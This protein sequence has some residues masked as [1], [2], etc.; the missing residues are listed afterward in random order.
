MALISQYFSRHSHTFLSMGVLSAISQ[1]SLTFWD[2]I[3]PNHSPFP[4]VFLDVCMYVCILNWGHAYST[5]VH[6]ASGWLLHIWQSCV[7]QPY[8]GME[9][10]WEHGVSVCGIYLTSWSEHRLWGV[11]LRAGCTALFEWSALDLVPG[12]YV[13]MYMYWLATNWKALFPN[14]QWRNSPQRRLVF[15]LFFFFL[16]RLKDGRALWWR[17][18]F[19]LSDT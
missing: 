14:G 18:S 15:Y 12:I 10:F 17:N 13:Y 3:L 6:H 16:K 5:Y 8:F 4:Y 19:C 11:T 9:G 1:P 7:I 2:M